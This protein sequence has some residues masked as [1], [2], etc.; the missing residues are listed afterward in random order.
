MALLCAKLRQVWKVDGNPNCG[1][2][3]EQPRVLVK[4]TE[5]G[6]PAGSRDQGWNTGPMLMRP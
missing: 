6:T 3:E 4:E 5:A 1:L 2:W